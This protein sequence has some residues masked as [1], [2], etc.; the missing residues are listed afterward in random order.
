MWSYLLP[1][2]V[3]ECSRLAGA[4]R[5]M[6]I[7]VISSNRVEKDMYGDRRVYEPWTSAPLC[8]WMQC[9]RLDLGISYE[10]GF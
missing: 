9:M 6:R 2:R 3:G 10:V 7:R 5:R 1:Y 4:N 8:T